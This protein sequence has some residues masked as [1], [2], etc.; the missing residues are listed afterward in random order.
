VTGTGE[1]TP[2]AAGSRDGPVG[3]RLNNS[4][5]TFSGATSARWGTADAM[6]IEA[7][8]RSDLCVG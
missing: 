4:D 5:G 8:R 1:S 7:R 6:T 3:S 2:A